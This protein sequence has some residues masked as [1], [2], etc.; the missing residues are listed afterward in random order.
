MTIIIDVTRLVRNQIKKRL[1][2]GIDRVTMAYVHHYGC[3]ALALMRWG[4]R[5]WIL[6]KKQ[7]KDLFSWLNAPRSSI[8]LRLILLAGLFS[9]PLRKKNNNTFLLNTGHIGLNQPDYARLIHRYGVKPIFLVHDLIPITHPEYCCE[10]EDLRHKEKM[11]LVLSLASG[12][13]TNSEATHQDLI[14]YAHD[15]RQHLPNITT[16]LLATGIIMAPPKERPLKKPYFVVLSTIEPRKN[17]ILLLQIWRSLVLRLREQTP[18]LFV[19]GQR[20]WECENAL[21]LLERCPGLKHVVT[22]I[23]RCSDSDLVTY[24]H[25]SQALLF[26]SFIEGY[27]LP[28]VEAL[29]LGV[30]VLASD[31]PV[32]HEIATNIPDYLDPLDGVRWR[33]MIID[34]AQPDS[35][36]RAAQMMRL[37]TFQKPTWDEHF[38]QVD[39]LLSRLTQ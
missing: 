24:L 15:T 32:F 4:G 7:S 11:N 10:G 33:E 18:H 26:P 12:I 30:P 5:S 28:L 20:G 13:I 22:E 3:S 27:G 14:A 23:P 9:K 35:P 6:P 8:R 34:Y 38:H 29:T 37:Q 19:I 16:A 2:T 25:H 17:H 39:A 36:T 1:P 21:D 31:L